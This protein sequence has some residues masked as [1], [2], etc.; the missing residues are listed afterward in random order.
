[1]FFSWAFSYLFISFLFFFSFPFTIEYWNSAGSKGVTENSIYTDPLGDGKYRW[2]QRRWSAEKKG[3]SLSS[4]NRRNIIPRWLTRQS[5]STIY[6]YMHVCIHVCVCILMYIRVK[7]WGGVP[8]I[9][10]ILIYCESIL[11]KYSWI[12]AVFFN[13]F[14]FV[15]FILFFY[16]SYFFFFCSLLGDFSCLIYRWG[17][18]LGWFSFILLFIYHALN[19]YNLRYWL[20]FLIE[21]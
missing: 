13:V 20:N 18:D 4:T 17:R 3:V 6:T 9:T 19:K 16:L 8:I 5:F 2:R 10:G 12:L 11:F 14:R 1:M 7:R 15:S 21:V